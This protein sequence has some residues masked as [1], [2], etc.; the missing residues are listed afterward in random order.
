MKV[1]VTLVI[2]LFCMIPAAA[3]HAAT[4]QNRDQIEH[5]L[6]VI[7]GGAEIQL[8]VSPGR[9]LT[10]V[11]KT[12]CD[13]YVGADPVPYDLISSDVLL[14]EEGQLL[15]EDDRKPEADT[16]PPAQTQ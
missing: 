15:Y 6:R 14:I 8:A 13:V 1:P 9:A 12:K 3:S 4:I 10:G 5:Q 7:E 11:C 2:C 16:G